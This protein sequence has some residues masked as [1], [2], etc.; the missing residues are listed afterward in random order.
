MNEL[1]LMVRL[2]VHGPITAAV[3]QQLVDDVRAGVEMI[4][5]ETGF[6]TE[7]QVDVLEVYPKP[8]DE[9]NA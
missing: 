5:N 4:R 2:S 3:T 8:K 1:I 7:A 9:S 6:S